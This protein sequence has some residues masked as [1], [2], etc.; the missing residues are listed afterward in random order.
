MNK[1]KI[2]LSMLCRACGQEMVG[3]E[4]CPGCSEAIHWKCNS[5]K[6]E[7]EKSIH[8]HEVRE[9]D[10]ETPSA[11][12]A[13]IGLATVAAVSSCVSGLSIVTCCY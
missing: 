1:Q 2:T 5:C 7:N 8:I 13:S 3:F 10:K 12:K 6:K 11:K 4:Y 9:K